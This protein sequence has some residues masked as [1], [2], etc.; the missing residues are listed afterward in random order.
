MFAQ[1]LRQPAAKVLNIEA[2]YLQIVLSSI[3]RLLRIICCFI[4]KGTN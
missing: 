4:M 1:H 3:W 2:L